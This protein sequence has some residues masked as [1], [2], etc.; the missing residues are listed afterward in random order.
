VHQDGLVHVSQLADR[1]IRD[2]ADVVS[3]GQKVSVTVL[4]VDLQRNRIALSMKTKPALAGG[5]ATPE[6][7]SSGTAGPRQ[8]TKLREGRP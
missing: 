3:V 6:I 5:G 1:F 2:P 4:S 7:Y 8:A